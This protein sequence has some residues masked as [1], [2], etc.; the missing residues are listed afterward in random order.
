M[1]VALVIFGCDGED[2]DGAPADASEPTASTAATA[3][4]GAL[5]VPATVEAS[6]VETT[7]SLRFVCT[8]TV[9]PPQPVEIAFAPV[10][11]SLAE[12]VHASELDA[13]EHTID[14]YF[15][16]PLADYRFTTRTRHDPPTGEVTGALTTGSVPDG[17]RV[18]LAVSG[19]ST[20][21]TLGLVSPCADDAVVVIHDAATGALLWYEDLFRGG[22][23]FVEAA[24]FTEDRT[25]L[26]LTD[27]HV[28]EVDLMGRPL[29]EIEPEALPERV[30]HDVFRRDGRTY[31]LYQEAVTHAGANYLLD[32]F[33]VYDGG[34]RV[35][36]W[37]LFDVYQPDSEPPG[38]FPIDHSHGNAIWVDEVG[39][40]L[41]SFRHLSTVAKVDGLDRPTFGELQWRLAGS[42]SPWGTDLVLDGT[43]EQQ[44][45]P[46]VLPDGRLVLL[47]NR[48][49]ILERS[50]VLALELDEGEGT[51]RID[52]S[53]ELPLHCPFQGAA[54]LTPAGN[55]TG[56]CASYRRYWEY[57][58]DGADP[59]YEVEANCLL[60]IPQYVPRI[61]PLD[62]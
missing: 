39:D 17:A 23:G 42:P 55:P 46:H 43:F 9:D 45:N 8:V 10:D 14:L 62:W 16:R 13:A 11:G 54:W 48:L 53:W 57:P 34:L 28:V 35:A 51:A 58:V 12:R 25:V 5:L 22:I 50:R 41:L 7:N 40:V 3:D 20:A 33:Y 52:A 30:H 21:P 32:G 38:P 37:R 15:L 27:G 18:A 61:V 60:G 1:L 2:A 4:T 6:C 49:S 36:D 47:D 29:L 59:S 56:T 31:V 26:A 19:T 44:H 24:S